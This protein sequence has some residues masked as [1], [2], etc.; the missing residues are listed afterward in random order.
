[1]TV[2]TTRSF[3][4]GF[5]LSEIALRRIVDIAKEQAAKLQSSPP[6]NVHFKTRLV[7]GVVEDTESLDFVVNQDNIGR[8]EVQELS[9]QIKL[10]PNQDPPTISL[11]FS[12]PQVLDRASP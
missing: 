9:I 4:H 3:S 7:N 2:A 8:S 1:M 12:N 11:R 6:A 5:S 10:A